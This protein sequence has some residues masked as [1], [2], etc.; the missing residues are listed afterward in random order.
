MVFATS[1]NLFLEVN[2]VLTLHFCRWDDRLQLHEHCLHS[3]DDC[4]VCR[5]ITRC[6]LGGRQDVQTRTIRPVRSNAGFYLY[7]LTELM[8][9]CCFRLH[10][11]AKETPKEQIRSGWTSASF[12]KY[13]TKAPWSPTNYWEG[14]L[15]ADSFWWPSNFFITCNLFSTQMQGNCFFASWSADWGNQGRGSII[16]W[17]NNVHGMCNIPNSIMR[18]FFLPSHC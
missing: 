5:M 7:Y 18:T 10:Y 15:S 1:T 11:R 8:S 4:P 3:L 14:V 6:E 12:W 9:F 17:K 2:S 13:S 16:Y